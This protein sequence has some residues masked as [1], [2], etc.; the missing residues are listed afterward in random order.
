MRAVAVTSAF[1]IPMLVAAEP[2]LPTRGLL[3]DLD[4]AKGLLVEDGD[5]VARWTSQAAGGL[6]FGKRDEGRQE[7]GSGRPTLRKSVPELG[8]KPALVFR[9]QELVCL[10]EDVLD[11]LSTGKGHTWIAL[12]AAHEQRPGLKDV[13][14]FFGNL[15]NRGGKFEGVWGCISDDNTVWWGART[16]VTFGRF[17]ANNPKLEGPRLAV[18]KFHLLAGRMGAGAGKVELEL[19]VD[20][21]SP[22]ASAKVAVNP[23]ADPSRMAVGQERDAIEH[24]GHESFDGELARFLV[25]ERPLDDRELA[26]AVRLLQTVY[27]TR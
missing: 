19:F 13:N 5:R 16:G 10:D 22:V 27:S 7:P 15:R 18:G 1:L 25:W 21:A 4:A 2:A 6:V 20:E 26:E 23:A 24:P 8:G 11:G 14:S 9:Q 17:D 12:L 3:I